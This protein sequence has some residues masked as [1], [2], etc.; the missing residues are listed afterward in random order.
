MMFALVKLY[1][2]KKCGDPL[3]WIKTTA[4]ESTVS[5]G[6]LVIEG[7]TLFC[8]CSWSG[9]VTDAR[10]QGDGHVFPWDGAPISMQ[11]LGTQK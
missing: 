1:A 6:E 10:E 9:P 8:N 7:V 2:C 5:E 3:V 11:V 4:S